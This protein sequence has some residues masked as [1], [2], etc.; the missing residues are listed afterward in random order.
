[1]MN[2]I[3]APLLPLAEQTRIVAPLEELLRWCDTLAALLHP[4]R[5]PGAHLLYSTH[6]NLLAA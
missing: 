6:H 1:M 3:P 5:T 4:T 2:S